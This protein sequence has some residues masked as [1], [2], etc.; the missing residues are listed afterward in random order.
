MS[1]HPMKQPP[2]EVFLDRMDPSSRDDQLAFFRAVAGVGPESAKELT[3]RVMKVSCPSDLKRLAVEASYYYPWPE[4]AGLLNSLLR[5]EKGLAVFETGVRALGRIRSADALAALRELGQTRG[6]PE[7]REIVDEVLQ[8]SDPAGAFQHHF[9]RLLQGSAAAADANEGAHRLASLLTPGSLEPL[10]AIVGHPDPLVYRHALRLIGRIP[11]EA[12]GEFLLEYLQGVHQDALEDR[13]VRVLLAAFRNLPKPEVLAKTRQ[14]LAS[15]WED[16]QLDAAAVLAS[17]PLAQTVSVAAGLRETGPGILDTFLIEVLLAAAEPK[18]THLAKC[19]GQAADTAQ[20][21]TRRI[22]FAMDAVAEGLADLAALGHIQADRVVPVLVETLQQHTA[23]PGV[24]GALARLVPAGS[25]DLLDLLLAHPDGPY[26]SAAVEAL[27]ARKDPALREPLL[28]ARRDPIADIADRA[29][30]HLGQ[31]P[32]AAATARAFLADPDPE[33][34]LV[35]LRFIAMHR[36][37]E[38]VPELL[39][40]A[41]SETREAVLEALLATIGAIGSPQAVE[42]LIELLHSGQGPRIQIALAEALRDLAD[43]PGAFVLCAKAQTLKIPALQ[44]VAV[45]ALV[46]AHAIQDAPFP[47]HRSASLL[48]AVRGAWSDRNPWPLRRRLAEALPQLRPEDPG[49]RTDL[50]ELVQAT[51][52]EKR[53][54]GEVAPEV[55]AQIQACARALAQ[56][57]Q[58]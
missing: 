18:P 14:T 46:R 25:R 38:L 8:S 56:Q 43:I 13:E 31:L 5:H 4:W 10:R 17:G 23:R 26:R 3:G 50:A 24:A 45:E 30:W 15:H 6:T 42:P 19:L 32:E 58:A 53:P 39:D 34:I 35:G 54:P 2:F 47:A 51:L 7:F 9:S 27:G 33:E 48:Q 36:L 22:E 20:R 52:A 12:A 49:L 41:A 11:T 44:A 37:E 28:A 21:H 57:P 1:V 29:I 40:A 16:R 55:L